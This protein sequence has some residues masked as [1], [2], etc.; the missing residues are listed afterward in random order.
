MENPIAFN[1][2]ASSSNGILALTP[3]LTNQS[4]DSSLDFNGL[5]WLANQNG[6]V[7]DPILFGDY[8]EPQESIMNNEFN[9]FNDALFPMPD[10]GNVQQNPAVPLEPKLPPKKN[11][12]Q[13][14]ED[15]QSG[16]EPEVTSGEERQQYL[17]CNLLWFVH[18]RNHCSIVKTH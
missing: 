3:A 15:Q 14:I 8:R 18:S 12:M 1:T 2:L 16:K 10:L 17:T 11:L 9:F 6:G 7:F 4:Q 13:E 5:D